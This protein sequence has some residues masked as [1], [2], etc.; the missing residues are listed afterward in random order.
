MS[1]VFLWDPKTVFFPVTGSQRLCIA[2]YL[3][4]AP[5]LANTL[6]YVQL[7]VIKNSLPEE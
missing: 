6:P 1:S 7:V 3:L 5:V 4:A 2:W